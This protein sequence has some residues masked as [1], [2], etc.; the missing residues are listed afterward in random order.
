VRQASHDPELVLRHW[1]TCT[2]VGEWCRDHH[3]YVPIQMAAGST[4]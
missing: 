1:S 4:V 3:L 2:T